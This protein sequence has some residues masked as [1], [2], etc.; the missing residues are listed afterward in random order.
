[1]D[2]SDEGIFLSGKSLGEANLIA[3]M[4]TL[5]HGRHLGLVRGGRSRR[6]RPVLQSGNLVRV[7]WRARLADHLGGYNVELMEA[8]GA[9][10]L[11]DPRA[12]AAIGMLAEFVKLLPERD[13]H[14]E[15]YATTLHVL[16]SFAE[17]DIWPA[18]LVYW[19]FQLLQELGFGLDLT[20]CAAT[21]ETED[22]VYVSPK[23]GRAVSREA[24]APYAAKMLR[25]PRFLVDGDARIQPSEIVAGF[26]L[27]G[28]F[29]E[30][31]VLAPHGLKVPD[32]RNRLIDLLRRDL[33][34]A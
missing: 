28:F 13:P 21:G 26:E 27:T 6:V 33:G 3:E 1:M 24:G 9:R 34:A 8:H 32:A 17:P 7:T 11:D 30:R 29:L 5:E 20:S 23:S 15:L 18:L 31:D 12:L 14:P 22:L 16:R 2:W 10:A 25:L 19:E 4:L